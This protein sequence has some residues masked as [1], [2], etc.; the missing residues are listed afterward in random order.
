M[1][2]LSLRS[3]ASPPPSGPRSGNSSRERCSGGEQSIVPGDYQ[4]PTSPYETCSRCNHRAY[5]CTC[6]LAGMSAPSVPL[7]PPSSSHSTTSLASQQQ[8]P[9]QDPPHMGLPTSWEN[10]CV[11]S[12]FLLK[13][14]AKCRASLEIL[15]EISDFFVFINNSQQVLALYTLRQPWRRLPMR[16]RSGARLTLSPKLK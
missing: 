4:A 3:R 11:P 12:K 7:P 14:I 13:M 16:P 2:P 6:A 10:R 8:R 15:C 5:A 1:W 9:S